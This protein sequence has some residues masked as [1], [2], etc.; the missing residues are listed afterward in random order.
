MYF[1]PVFCS[2]SNHFFQKSPF[3]KVYLLKQLISSSVTV[4]YSWKSFN[5]L[6]L[7]SSILIFIINSIVIQGINEK[8]V[9]FLSCWYFYLWTDHF[10][11]FHSEEGVVFCWHVSTF[12]EIF[13]TF[14]MNHHDWSSVEP[15]LFSLSFVVFFTVLFLGWWVG[16]QNEG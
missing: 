11:L 3:F 7:F 6:I 8:V 12:K 15:Y 10:G 16:V 14:S 2:S 9:F 4:R 13:R 1:F 5:M